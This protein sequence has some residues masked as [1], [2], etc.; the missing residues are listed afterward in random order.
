MEIVKIYKIESSN[1]INVYIGSTIRK[2]SVRLA[3]HRS[4]LKRYLM[5]KDVNYCRSY[6]I[7]AFGNYKIELIEMCSKTDRDE[8]ERWWIDNTPNTV[9]KLIP[10]R[11]LI[12]WYQDHKEE[13]KEYQQKNKEKISERKNKKFDCECGGKYTHSAKA[14]HLK[15]KK[16]QDWLH[17]N[18]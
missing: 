15:S 5:G 7:L 10:G 8:R 18:P 1:F 9:N 11:T 4:A 3:S 12:E 16:H 13:I 2:L 17:T 14:R 6:D